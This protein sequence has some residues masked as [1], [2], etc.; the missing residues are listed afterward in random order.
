MR[1]RVGRNVLGGQC[2]LGIF[3]GCAWT[4]SVH[5]L[6]DAGVYQFENIK[7]FAQGRTE[8]VVDSCKSKTYYFI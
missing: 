3:S 4:W 2:L 1:E 7:R 6:K 8:V 5:S